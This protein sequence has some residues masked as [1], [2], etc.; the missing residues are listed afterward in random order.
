MKCREKDARLKARPEVKARRN[1]RAREKQYY[2]AYRMRRREEDE[3]AFL[4]HN[5]EVMRRWTMKNKDHVSAW[6]KTN[7]KQRLGGIRQQAQKKG[8][9]WSLSLDAAE[10]LV[11]GAC[12]YCTA[13]DEVCLNGIDRVD[14]DQGYITG[15]VVS[16]CKTCNFMKCCLDIA[17]F[18]ERCKHISGVEKF[19]NAWPDCQASTYSMYKNRAVKKGLSF[20]I[21]K[22]DFGLLCGGDCAYCGKA[23]TATHRNGID[24]VDNDQGYVAGNVR[25]CCRE[26]NHMKR[27]LTVEQFRTAC[28][29][30]AVHSQSVPCIEK[31][32]R[33]CIVRRQA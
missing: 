1:E 9:V 32:S 29:R 16:A 31:R 5:A 10:A 8:L 14:N 27:D 25:P 19:M 17:T 33:C 26:C 7:L 2:K 21:S 20:E 30:V 15:N 12:H 22:E 28:L 18:I 6:R 24:R 23:S 11:K 13:V 3:K 4:T